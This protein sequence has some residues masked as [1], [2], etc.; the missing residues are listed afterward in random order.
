MLLVTPLRLEDTPRDN[1]QARFF[2][3]VAEIAC[4]F[5]YF[6]GSRRSLGYA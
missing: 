4:E 1:R 2:L 3:R 5:Y 6:F